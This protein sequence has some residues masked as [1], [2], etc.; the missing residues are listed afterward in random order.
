MRKIKEVE[1]KFV[2]HKCGQYLSYDLDQ[3]SDTECPHCGHYLGSWSRVT[4][5]EI[6]KINCIKERYEVVI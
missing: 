4:R 6:V 3:R 2:C 5:R 1:I